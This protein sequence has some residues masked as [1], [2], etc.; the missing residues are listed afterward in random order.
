MPKRHALVIGISKYKSWTTLK[1]AWKDAES[2]SQCLEKYG[3]YQVTRI[4]SK[5]IIEQEGKRGVYKLIED[6]LSYTDLTNAIKKILEDTDDGSE[7][8]IYFAGHG[9]SAKDNFDDEYGYIA[10]SNSK[11]C[12]SYAIA[13]ESLNKQF[14]KRLKRSKSGLVVL[15]DC[16]YAGS[17]LEGA[18]EKQIFS[19][20]FASLIKYVN[21]GI[22]AACRRTEKAYES[23]ISDH[24]QFT[25][26]ILHAIEDHSQNDLLTFS[27]LAQYVA[28]A[29]RGT[30]QEPV[31]LA[32]QGSTLEIIN[33]LNKQNPK[34]QPI[35]KFLRLLFCLN[36]KKPDRIFREFM[37][38][39][40]R[41]VGAFWIRGK[42]DSAQKWLLYRLWVDFVPGSIQA[43][44]KT[45][46]IRTG[47]R[48][49]DLWQQLASW[50]ETEAEPNAIVEEILEQ[51]QNKKTVA[52]VFY[53]IERLSTDDLQAFI[54]NLWVPLVRKTQDYDI[55]TP[56]LLFFVD[57][58]RKG[59]R[60]CPIEY[61]TEYDCDR[62]E[63]IIELVADGFK[64]RDFRNWTEAH[65]DALKPH[66]NGLCP[67]ELK[68][69]AIQCNRQTD[70][71]PLDVLIELCDY[72]GVV[73]ERDIANKFLAG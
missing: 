35:E 23:D 17:I 27:G 39:F 6:Y 3:D 36:Y 49:E 59:D 22:L 48:I 68:D 62:P 61:G 63:Q 29:L 72:C 14:I 44:K 25:E 15:L 41:R 9:F 37:E 42:R 38:E 26:A 18:I 2:I 28:V 66:L 30:G 52:I 67:T 57:L 20:S 45:F 69:K 73:W 46:K 8:L 43:F 33:C 54:D 10:A 53:E 55:D 65:H 71:R 24:G 21:F 4:P 40:D 56:L 47:S 64:D 50:L 13:L 11:K 70:V 31:D 16:C 34:E 19:Q 58:G 12:G 51:W 7:L 1:N 32:L 5:Y 60:T